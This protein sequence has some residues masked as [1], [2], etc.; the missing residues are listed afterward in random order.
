MFFRFRGLQVF[1]SFHLDQLP[2]LRSFSIWS[3]TS[4]E[5]GVWGSDVLALAGF[6]WIFAR[7]TRLIVRKIPPTRMTGG[8][9]Y[10]SQLKPFLGGTERT[11][12]PYCSAKKS[13]NLRGVPTQGKL[14]ADQLPPICTC[15]RGAHIQWNVLANRAVQV[16]RHL[17]DFI[18]TD[19]VVILGK[20]PGRDCRGANDCQ[21]ENDSTFQDFHVCS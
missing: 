5:T 2:F 12:S 11:F 14:L 15:L 19:R 1:F 8:S 18:I 21:K 6:V 4:S 3:I 20:H 9:R 7:R 16:L 17:V 13:S 10:T